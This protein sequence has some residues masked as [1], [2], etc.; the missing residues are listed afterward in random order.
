MEAILDTLQFQ[1]VN[2]IY[3]GK[4]PHNYTLRPNV[5]LLLD[6]KLKNSFPSYNYYF[7]KATTCK[8]LASHAL[9]IQNQLYKKEN[10]SFTASLGTSY[11]IRIFL[12][13]SDVSIEEKKTFYNFNKQFNYDDFCINV[14]YNA[15]PQDI[16]NHHDINWNY[17]AMSHSPHLSIPFVRSKLFY[18]DWQTLT[19]NDNLITSIQ[20]IND[21]PDL[22]WYFPFLI[23]NKNITFEDILENITRTQPILFDLFKKYVHQYTCKD[24]ESLN[25]FFQKIKPYEDHIIKYRVYIGIEEK[26][27]YK[28]YAF[29][30]DNLKTILPNLNEIE[31][32]YY[33]N[34]NTTLD[35]QTIKTIA[36]IKPNLSKYRI[37][38]TVFTPTQGQIDTFIKQHFASKRIQRY[39]KRS[40][41]NP[42]YYLCR[43]RLLREFDAFKNNQ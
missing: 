4:L 11:F 2:E 3:L 21:N 33:L 7:H 26:L 42:N 32:Q 41:S 12:K 10:D 14:S 8:P 27:E 43:R 37:N 38:H 29:D 1:M 9:E 40:I 30:Y 19:M 17:F 28:L 34:F 13:R 22:R 16:I 36:A 24:E 35:F 25:I 15:L 6:K 20:T 39:W 5:M 18:W 31:W 23:K